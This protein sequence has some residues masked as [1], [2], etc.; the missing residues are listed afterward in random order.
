[1][2]RIKGVEP[3]GPQPEDVQTLILTIFKLNTSSHPAPL[4]PSSLSCSI[5]A[6][7][8]KGQVPAYVEECSATLAA[9]YSSG[10]GTERRIV[11]IILKL[12]IFCFFQYL[13]HSLSWHSLH[14]N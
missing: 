4:T 11:G 5:S 2:S 6:V 12:R 9:A 3:G 8:D 7:N 13:S 1:M 10:T 14:M